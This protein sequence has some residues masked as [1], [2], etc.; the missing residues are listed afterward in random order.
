MTPPIRDPVAVIDIG[1][2]STKLLITDGRDRLRRSVDTVMGGSSLSATGKLRGE[3]ITAE[4]LDR[5]EVALSSFA[6][7]C[8]ARN[9]EHR[10]VIGTASAR[11]AV[12]ADA[13]IDLVENTIGV[14]LEI[15]TPDEEADMAYR[16]AVSGDGLAIGAE[17]SVVTIDFGGGSTEFA[18]G[19]G[20]DPQH[21]QSIPIGGSLVSDTYLTSD[22]PRP[23]ELSAAL[24]VVELHLDDVSRELPQLTPILVDGTTIAVGAITTIAAIEVGLNDV[25]PN[26]GE[27]D[28][29]LHGFKLTRAAVEDVFRTIAT[30]DREDRA[31]NPGLPASRVD[32]VVGA[33]AVIVETMRVFDI[34]HLVVSQRGALDGLASEMLAAQG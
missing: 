4:A 30:E 7:L 17:D 1:S 34:E 8:A 21:R 24:S 25:D 2:V 9:V 13:V 20:L 12:N 28:G 18:A 6:A 10:R 19:V 16:G 27:G 32:D 5:L 23:E 22:P 31:F 29:P 26:S 3:I 14:D 11:R 33:C 15:L